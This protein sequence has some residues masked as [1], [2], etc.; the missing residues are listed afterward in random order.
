MSD[1][2]P[3]RSGSSTYTPIRLD[4]RT[5]P[6][7]LWRH[8]YVAESPTPGPSKQ[9]DNMK[10]VKIEVDREG[11]I[12]V[13]G[14]GFAGKACDAPLDQIV[15]AMGGDP[16]TAT[17]SHKPEYHLETGRELGTEGLL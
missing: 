14:D 10:K 6:E 1:E 2:L 12:T 5:A 9:G 11:R 8:E 17:T 15:R 13:E 4:V 7:E 3:I 16:A